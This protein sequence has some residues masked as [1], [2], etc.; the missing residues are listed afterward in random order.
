M[1]E[2]LEEYRKIEHD[3]ERKAE[4]DALWDAHQAAVIYM[5]HND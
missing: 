1:T 2:Y 4:A 3:P 5:Y